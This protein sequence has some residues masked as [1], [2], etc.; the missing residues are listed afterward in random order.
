MNISA[1]EV[2]T[3]LELHEMAIDSAMKTFVVKLYLALNARDFQKKSQ[4]QKQ[5]FLNDI[6]QKL[7]EPHGLLDQLQAE[8]RVQANQAEARAQVQAAGLN[9]LGSKCQS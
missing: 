6:I 1:Q 8:G 7:D 3:A 9:W 2:L 4:P 5:A